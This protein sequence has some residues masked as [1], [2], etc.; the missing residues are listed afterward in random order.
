[1]VRLQFCPHTSLHLC[2][3][4]MPV[5]RS[6]TCVGL[7]ADCLSRNGFEIMSR[8][9]PEALN[10]AILP[11]HVLEMRL[12]MF[13]SERVS[14]RFVLLSEKPDCRTATIAIFGRALR[15]RL[16]WYAEVSGQFYNIICVYLY[17]SKVHLRVI[18]ALDLRL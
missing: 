1:M 14:D 6:Y 10:T 5:L 8:E 4:A 7:R 15:F 18:A 13:W 12:C 17:A 9:C 16:F 2:V 3:I 11:L